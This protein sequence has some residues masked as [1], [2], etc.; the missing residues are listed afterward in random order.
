MVIIAGYEEELKKCFF[1][2]NQG[3]DSRF[4]WRFK[5]DDYTAAELNLIFQKK[6]KEIEWSLKNPIKDSW[7][8]NNKKYFSFYG[9]DIETLLAK[10]KI[11]H[12][13]RV[14]CLNKKYKKIITLKD[15]NNG[16]QMFLENEEV[17]NRN[18]D[19]FYNNMYC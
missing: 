8:E 15:L 13:K 6:I 11:A 17:K 18:N 16:F 9:R 1:E 14:F 4:T 5:T 12:S 10:T 19:H 7:F 3:L 2:Y